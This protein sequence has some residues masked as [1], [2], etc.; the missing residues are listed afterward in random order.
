MDLFEVGESSFDNLESFNQSLSEVDAKELENDLYV[1]V[2]FSH[3]DEKGMKDLLDHR[4]YTFEDLGAI[5][6]IR[7]DYDSGQDDGYDGAE[8]YY[9]YDEE[10]GLLLFYSDMRKTEE[11]DNTIVN[12]LKA[13]PDVHYLHVSPQVFQTLRKELEKETHAEVTRFVADRKEG[14]DFPAR[15]RGEYKR[16]I[17]YDGDDGLQTLREMETNYGVRPRNLTFEVTNIVKFRATRQGIFAYSW[18][19]IN[20]FIDYV[21]TAIQKALEAKKAF[22]ASSFEMVST[23]EA[24]SVPTS[25]P[26]TIELDHSL[27]Y[28][29]ME[30]IASRMEDE[31]YLVVDS[32]AQEGSVYF[33]SKIIDTK[34]QNRFRLQASGEK[35][36][37]YPQEEDDKV[38]S[39]LR[40]YEFVQNNIDPNTSITA[41]EG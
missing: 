23:T 26:A 13:E 5:D 40:F 38:G 33:S 11:I 7:R 32:F 14:S 36:H 17:Q 31:G 30:Q 10:S 2:G 41:A 8:Y 9:H 37:V 4:G 20:T 18:G 24:L 25:E 21:E 15:I 1:V 28:D 19:D 34:K 12:L 35:I 16:T 27:Q 39:F 29:E 3:L 22:D 6:R